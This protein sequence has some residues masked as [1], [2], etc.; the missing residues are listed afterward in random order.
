[1]IKKELGEY[2]DAEELTETY[3]EQLKD[4]S[5]PTKIKQKIRKE[6]KRLGQMSPNN[7]ESGYIRAWLETIFDLPWGDR[8]EQKIDLIKA[9]KILNSN[10]YGLSDVKDRILEYIAV[11]QLKKAKEK[12]KKKKKKKLTNSTNQESPTILCFVGPPGV[13]KTSIGRAIAKSLGRK[14]T[15]I[16]LGG[17]RDEAQIRGHRR[18]YV[19]AMPGRII[20]GI[21]QAESLNPVFILD[22]I[23]KVG[24][25]FRGDPS[26]AL[27]EVLD[28]EQNK[29]FEDHYLDFPFDLSEVIFITTANTLD[30][31]PPAL[32]DRLE[33][34]RYPGYTF[35]EKFNIAKKHLMKKVLHSN[36]LDSSQIN[37]T[38]GALKKI[39]QR[40]TKEAG[41]RELE[42]QLNKTC[43]KVAKKIVAHQT[44]QKTK[45]KAKQKK[46][47][48]KKNLL[49]KYLG[50]EKY[51]LT[52]AE[53]EDQIGVATGLA[54]TRTGGD[55]LFI[56][57]G[58]TPGKGKIRLTG[59]LGEV[60]KES[61]QT[62]LTFVK[63]NAKKL[64]IDEDRFDKT[65]VHIHV[66]EGAVPKDGPSAGITMATA[67]ASAFTNKSVKRE[68]AM[69]G[70]ITLRGRV[71]R[72]GG[73]KEKVIAAHL[74]GIKQIIIPEKNKRDLS[75]ISADIKKQINFKPVNSALEVLGL[76]LNK[77]S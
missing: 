17:I 64:K 52:L 43:R 4:K 75:E 37:I 12:R 9:E 51:D 74:A 77:R 19:G 26:A 56:E 5:I 54:W 28:P 72:I 40:Y 47:S 11:L 58:L 50:P 67:I 42:R 66:P 65:D 1:T 10:H 63:A 15:K 61:A 35:D 14:F 41:V 70:E 39:I 3:Q 6:L 7:P 22:E 25:D 21:K 60:M 20:K 76:T 48:V 18:T 2:D 49:K 27:L 16:S 23:D 57:V 33:I 30:T 36:G 34:I 73:L 55:I 46:I 44:K 71:L 69:T 62:A 13:G 29:N 38:D 32:R 31:I 59:K 8:D 68:L 24:K 53:E 45:T